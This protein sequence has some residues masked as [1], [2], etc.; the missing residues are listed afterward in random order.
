M[1]RFEVYQQQVGTQG[2]VSQP[3]ADPAQFARAASLDGLASGLGQVADFLQQRL[4]QRELS[5]LNAAVSQTTA[6]LTLELQ[7]E[8]RGADPND[9]EFASRFTEKVGA[10]VDELN[11]KATTNAGRSYLTKSTAALRAQFLLSATQGQIELAGQAA[12]ANYQQSVNNDTSTLVADPAMLEFVLQ[13]QETVLDSMV[14]SGSISREQAIKLKAAS[15]SE[16]AKAAAAGWT[17]LD[18]N[19]AK[20]MIMA[21]TFD[22]YVDGT[23]KAQLLAGAEQAIRAEE[24]DKAR[25]EAA[26]DKALKKEQN[27]TKIQLL[28]DM[29]AD[30]PENPV[31]AKRILEAGLTAGDTEHFLKAIG[32]LSTTGGKKTDPSVMSD[33]LRRAYLPATDPDRLTEEEIMA[34]AGTVYKTSEDINALFGAVQNRKTTLGKQKADGFKNLHAVAV[35]IYKRNPLINDPAADAMIA[36]AMILSEQLYEDGIKAGKTPQQLL[37]SGSPDYIVR[38]WPRPTRDDIMKRYIEVTKENKYTLPL[39]ETPIGGNPGA[40][41][42]NPVPITS[43]EEMQQLA[44]GTYFRTPDGRVIR[45]G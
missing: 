4:E 6:D 23:T 36:D 38:S 15:N 25:A 2:A 40:S 27:A 32:E 1:P 14:Q 39:N 21:G 37:Y 7:D 18:G 26:A 11:D 9:S 35:G 10:R 3:K 24:I 31:T 12:V 29:A 28:A 16:A 43:P 30:D 34:G 5:E 42:A 20:E 17:Q 19:T 33:G 8:L 13:Q 45:K 44:P 41:P 22:P